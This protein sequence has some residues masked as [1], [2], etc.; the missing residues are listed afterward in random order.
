M[1]DH[2]WLPA[3]GS[4]SLAC[5][6]PRLALALDL[7]AL[8]GS[9]TPDIPDV[10]ITVVYFHMLSDHAVPNGVWL[11]HL[12]QL[13]RKSRRRVLHLEEVFRFQILSRELE[14]DITR[15]S[16]AVS[17]SKSFDLVHFSSVDC[18]VR[19]NLLPLYCPPA[20]WAVARTPSTVGR[21]KFRSAVWYH[22]LCAMWGTS[23]VRS[24]LCV[25]SRLFMLT[26]GGVV[27]LVGYGEIE[28]SRPV[29]TS[30]APSKAYQMRGRS[31][32]GSYV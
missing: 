29:S 8:V 27:Q 9:F 18:F 32:V 16:M 3:I 12:P 19:G 31:N 30:D 4:L 26:L 11:G 21:T 6:S 25:I 17:N 28:S 23:W 5:C 14:R 10:H 13:S 1:C 2:Q 22:G 15:A 7:E 24:P 20:C